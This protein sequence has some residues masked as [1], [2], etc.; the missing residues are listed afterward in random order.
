MKGGYQIVD[1]KGASIALNGAATTIAGVYETIRNSNGK[2]LVLH[3]LNC[4]LLTIENDI[5]ATLIADNDTYTGAIA[6][7]YTAAT[8]AA[9]AT[10]TGVVITITEDDAVTLATVPVIGT[11]VT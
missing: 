3:N 1:F 10:A 5:V 9:A 7:Q 6:T 11:A 4:D 8:E 2:L